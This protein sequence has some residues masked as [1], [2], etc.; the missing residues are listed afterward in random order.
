MQFRQNHVQPK[1]LVVLLFNKSTHK[2]TF[3]AQCN[4]HCV[5]MVVNAVMHGC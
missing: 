1:A 2:H 3:G 5:V 4:L